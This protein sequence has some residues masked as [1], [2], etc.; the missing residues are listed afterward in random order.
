MKKLSKIL[1]NSSCNHRKDS[2][3]LSENIVEVETA[4]ECLPV[5]K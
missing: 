5:K 1:H 3:K 4:L 2:K